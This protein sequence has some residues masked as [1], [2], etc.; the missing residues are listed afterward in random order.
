MTSDFFFNR[1]CIFAQLPSNQ[2]EINFFYGALLELF[3]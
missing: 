2:R 3:R 1:S